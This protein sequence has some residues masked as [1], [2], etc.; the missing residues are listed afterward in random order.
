MG[1]GKRELDVGQSHNEMVAE[2]NARRMRGVND[3]LGGDSDSLINASGEAVTK[4]NMEVLERFVSEFHSAK[5][6]GD[7]ELVREK[8]EQL[9]DG[10][11]FVGMDA[12]EV[13]RSMVDDLSGWDIELVDTPED[14]LVEARE[15]YDLVMSEL[16]LNRPKY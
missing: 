11:L 2:E 9:R 12:E 3:I 13:K 5:Q 4:Q 7:R 15:R 6:G 1:N 10:F 14:R 8:A 16:E